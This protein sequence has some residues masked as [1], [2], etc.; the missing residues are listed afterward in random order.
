MYTTLANS[1]KDF[2]VPGS[3]I[4]HYCTMG[5]SFVHNRCHSEIAY[6][7]QAHSYVVPSHYSRFIRYT[8]HSSL[9]A[10]GNLG[11]VLGCRAIREACQL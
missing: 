4:D 2:A 9:E 8:L 11:Y 3:S 10:K 6:T 7:K 5:Q 1:C